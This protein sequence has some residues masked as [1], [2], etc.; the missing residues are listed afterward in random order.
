MFK[1][2]KEGDL[3]ILDIHSGATFCPLL[4]NAPESQ[5]PCTQIFGTMICAIRKDVLLPIESTELF[6]NELV[7]EALKSQ[8]ETQ[9]IS[10]A[11]IIASIINKWKDGKN[12]KQQLLNSL[13][14]FFCVEEN[15]KAYLETLVIRLQ[16]LVQVNSLAALTVYIW[17]C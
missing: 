14:N 13:A 3:Q 5:I 1:L 15:F 17:V 4:A 11:R 7:E 12:I 10:L 8:N 2:F 9:V 16:D 6:L